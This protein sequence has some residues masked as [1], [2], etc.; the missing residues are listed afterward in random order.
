M[1]FFEDPRA[2]ALLDACKAL[3]EQGKP[4]VVK[5]LGISRQEARESATKWQNSK[6]IPRMRRGDFD[7]RQ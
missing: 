7:A 2:R 4:V 1:I 6:R 5:S 3:E